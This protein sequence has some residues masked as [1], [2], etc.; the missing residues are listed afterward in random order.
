MNAYAFRIL[1]VVGLLLT[2]EGCGT[3][4]KEKVV[5]HANVKTITFRLRAC[6][7]PT[8]EDKAFDTISRWSDVDR[9]GRIRPTTTNHVLRRMCWLVVKD[10]KTAG[11][12]LS[13]L[14]D[15]QEIESAS[16]PAARRLIQATKGK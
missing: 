13:R 1:L 5:E 15:M 16:S 14:K 9:V 7:D 4:A 3:A 6:D 2:V 12:V 11:V 8:I 10:D